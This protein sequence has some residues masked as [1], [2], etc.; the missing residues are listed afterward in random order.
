[1]RGEQRG[2]HPLPCAPWIPGQEK[3]IFFGLYMV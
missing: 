1:M 3:N 2:K